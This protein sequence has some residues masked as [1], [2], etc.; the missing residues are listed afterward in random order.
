MISKLKNLLFGQRDAHQEPQ[1]IQFASSAEKRT[2]A[3]PNL[4]TPRYDDPEIQII[5]GRFGELFDGKV[6]ETTL[7]ELEEILPRP[8]RRADAYASVS[9]RLATMGVTLVIKREVRHGK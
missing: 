2:E 5:A 4:D 7:A 9:K 6:I 3:S 1:N 8:R